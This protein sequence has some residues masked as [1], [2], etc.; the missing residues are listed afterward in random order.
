MDLPIPTNFKLI[1]SE[2]IEIMKTDFHNFQQNVLGTIQIT[3]ENRPSVLLL[4]SENMMH[5]SPILTNLIDNAIY[6]WTANSNE[7]ILETI[8]APVDV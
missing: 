2:L 6:M 8:Y 5:S 1:F 4:Y 7:K 3:D